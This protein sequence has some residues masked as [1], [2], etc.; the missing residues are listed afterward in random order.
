MKKR[1]SLW[2]FL[3]EELESERRDLIFLLM[4]FTPIVVG[5]AVAYFH[6]H[7]TGNTLKEITTLIQS[8]ESA[9]VLNHQSDANQGTHVNKE[10]Q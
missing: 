2:K 9:A 8:R 7:Y 5:L 1:F 3:R 10:N 6:L 4:M